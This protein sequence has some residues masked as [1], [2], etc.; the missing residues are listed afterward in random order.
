MTAID[1]IANA[2]KLFQLA[3]DELAELEDTPDKIRD[4]SE[5]AWGATASAVDAL[6]ETKTGKVIKKGKDRSK[7]LTQLVEDEQVVPADIQ[8]RYFSREDS[9]HGDC[10]YNGNCEPH[11][12]I[13]K[14]IRD[15]KGLIDDIEALIET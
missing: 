9:L 2:R 6:I 7:L 13:A 12:R 3:I 4:A 1:K 8:A 15:T 14:R 10:F 5:K 11:D